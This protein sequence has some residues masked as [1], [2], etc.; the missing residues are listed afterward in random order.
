MAK[1]ENLKTCSSGKVEIITGETIIISP[2]HGLDRPNETNPGCIMT[3][4][5][6]GKKVKLKEVNIIYDFCKLLYADLDAVGLS[7]I[8]LKQRIAETTNDFTIQGRNNVANQIDEEVDASLQLCVHADANTKGY[9]GITLFYI[10]GKERSKKIAD[11]FSQRLNASN[12]STRIKP[13]TYTNPGSLGELRNTTAP[14]LLIEIGTMDDEE[15]RKIM[16]ERE[17]ILSK[18]IADILKSFNKDR[19][20]WN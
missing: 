11:Y 19:P 6:N 17:K 13:D 2:G 12:L 14:A 16:Y 20:N 1:I 4:T 8:N 5:Q 18:K 15:G 9:T 7:Y 3:I 10:D